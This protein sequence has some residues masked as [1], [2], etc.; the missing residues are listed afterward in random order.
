MKT[1]I[2]LLLLAFVLKLNKGLT[3]G[4]SMGEAAQL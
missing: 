3:G 4:V 1:L 2:F